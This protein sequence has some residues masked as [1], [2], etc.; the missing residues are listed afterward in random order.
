MT[1]DEG[2]HI[3][4]DSLLDSTRW[5]ATFEQDAPLVTSSAGSKFVL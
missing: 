3:G 5:N 2:L 1:Q 4:N